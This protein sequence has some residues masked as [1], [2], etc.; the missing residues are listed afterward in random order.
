MGDHASVV[1]DCTGAWWSR[2]EWSGARVRRLPPPA[3][4]GSVQVV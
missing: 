3:T 4:T 2:Q 1:L